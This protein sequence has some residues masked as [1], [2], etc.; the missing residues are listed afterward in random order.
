M[1]YVITEACVDI[2]DQS[3]VRECPVD[4]IYEGD[5][6]MYIHPAECIDCGACEPVCPEN[7]IYYEGDLEEEQLPAAERQKELFLPLGMLKGARKNGPLDT[8]HP[9]IAALPPRPPRD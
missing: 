2:K 9:F 6:Q 1:P 4:C 8:D 7:A 5:R 3:C